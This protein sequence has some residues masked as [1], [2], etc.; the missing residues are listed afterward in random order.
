MNCYKVCFTLTS[1][2]HHCFSFPTW[3]SVFSVTPQVKAVVSEGESATPQRK[4]PCG[5]FPSVRC[6]VPAGL[7]WRTD[8][9]KPMRSSSLVSHRPVM[10]VV[11]RHSWHVWSR[12]RS[13]DRRSCLTP[14]QTLQMFPDVIQQPRL[15]QARETRKARVSLL[16][17]AHM[18]LI[19]VSESRPNNGQLWASVIFMAV[20][21]QFRTKLCQIYLWL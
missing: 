5:S 21:F 10:R 14:E 9:H 3:R 6:G 11:M 8:T 7:R 1:A 4:P 2:G 13:A 20:C 19:F 17:R 16:F 12:T 18:I 15:L